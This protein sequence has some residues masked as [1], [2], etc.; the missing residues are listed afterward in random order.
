MSSWRSRGLG[1]AGE[2][3][4]VAGRGTGE[5]AGRVL[6]RVMGSP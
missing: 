4:G 3:R 1:P 6:G 5:I 2:P